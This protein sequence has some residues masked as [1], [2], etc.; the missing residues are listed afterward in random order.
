MSKSGKPVTLI[1]VGAG[2]RGSRYAEF[3]A[4]NPELAALVAVAEPKDACRRRIAHDHGIGAA[5]TVEDWRPLSE[6]ERFAD[7]VIIATSDAM[8]REPA[9]AFIKQG[10]HV[11]LEKPMAPD[12]TSCRLI[13]KEALSKKVLFSVCHVLR[14]TPYTQALK[15]VLDSGAIGEVVSLQRL[16]PVGYWHQA[17]SFVRGN[18]RNER[19]SS[20][21]LLAKSCHDL[22]WIH[23]IMGCRCLKVSSF[24]A[25]NH[26]RREKRPKGASERCV[27]CAVE[28]RCPY[29]AKKIYLERVSQGHS[30]WPVS[31]L[32]IET[33]E[34]SIRKAIE[35]GPYGR[36]V[37]TCDNDVVDNQ[38]VNLLFEG[39][40]TASFTMTAF[41]RFASRRTRIFGTHGEIYG[42]G[43]QIKVHDFLTDKT[44][45]ID[46]EELVP[47]IWGGHGGGDG[48]LM[49]SYLEAV[50]DRDPSKILSGPK[51]TLESHIM[52][53]AAER[54]RR[55]GRTVDM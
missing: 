7:A 9:V 40:K 16:E 1:L 37:Y 10:Y 43:S 15:K 36:C 21:M 2:N 29:S 34:D 42:N 18:W 51:E 27:T 28:E 53:F 45:V 54:S 19:Q 6:R 35:T 50:A 8:H 46:T 39:G 33:S 17:H 22:D 11:L 48:S 24:G 26:F 52:V 13:V 44:E 23:Y 5:D 20:S 32:A 55:E 3:V 12:E 31:V 41:T 49:K 4:N 25:L 14:Y 30:G 38:V 47:G